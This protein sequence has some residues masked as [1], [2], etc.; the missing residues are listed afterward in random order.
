MKL[1]KLNIDGPLVLEPRVFRDERGY[2]YE[3]YRSSE[4]AEHGI[5]VDFVQDNVSSS[6]R[7][8]LRGLHYQITSP[9]AKLIQCLKGKI[10]DIAVDLRQ[11][12]PT[13]GQHV[14][15][16]LSDANKNGFYIPIGF[17]HGFAVLSEEAL[18]SYKCS[19][20]YSPEGE[21]GVRWN[22]PELDIE[23]G[24]QD[25]LLSEKDQKLPYLADI[26]EQDLFT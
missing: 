16:E 3:S 1:N 13:F 11:S 8:T 25:P 18:I 17:A 24:I 23:W 7:H 22:D 4:F 2:F 14:A 19:D 26:K 20:Y 10:I 5:T 15:V 6:V 21:R 12:S 9:Q